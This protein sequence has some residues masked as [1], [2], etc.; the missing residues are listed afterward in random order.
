MVGDDWS[1][2]IRHLGMNRYEIDGGDGVSVVLEGGVMEAIAEW[3]GGSQPTPPRVLAGDD[4]T[5]VHYIRTGPSSIPDGYHIIQ[6]G[7]DKYRRVEP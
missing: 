2:R 3:W 4:Y 6:V 5:M 1:N 7:K